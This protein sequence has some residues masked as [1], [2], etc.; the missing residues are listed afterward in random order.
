[1]PSAVWLHNG[2][3]LTFVTVGFLGIFLDED[4]FETVIYHRKHFYYYGLGANIS[5][6]FCTFSVGPSLA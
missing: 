2:I 5:K 4:P 6:L 3:L 1:M